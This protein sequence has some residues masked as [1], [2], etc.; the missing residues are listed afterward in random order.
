MSENKQ[1]K[2]P[3]RF[4]DSFKR[5]AV[6]LVNVHGY[7]ILAAA[8]KLSMSDKTLY[9]WV[10]KHK[11]KNKTELTNQELVDEINYLKSELRRVNREKDVLRDAALIMANDAR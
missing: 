8:N 10:K 2:T 1:K 7:S 11:P 4:S 9:A 3:K 6:E 5:E